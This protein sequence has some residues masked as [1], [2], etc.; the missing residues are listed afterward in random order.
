MNHGKRG[1]FI[2]INNKIF[3]KDTGLEERRGTDVDSENLQIIFGD[4]LGFEVVVKNDLTRTEMLQLMIAG[5]F[6]VSVV[7]IFMHI[8]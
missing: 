7:K 4:I 6:S 1:R 5:I 3:G 2:I 8:G